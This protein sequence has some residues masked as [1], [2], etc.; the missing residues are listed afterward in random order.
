MPVMFNVSAK[1]WTSPVT[2]LL[3]STYGEMKAMFSDARFKKKTFGMMWPEI[4]KNL[5]T[6]SAQLNARRNGATLNLGM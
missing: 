2:T 5:D 4:W 6:R 3:I 1:E